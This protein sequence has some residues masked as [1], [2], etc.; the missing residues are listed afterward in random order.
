MARDAEALAPYLESRAHWTFGY[1]T[2]EREHDCVRFCDAGV[3]AVSGRHPLKSF[4]GTWTTERGA[5]RVLARHGGMAQAVSTVMAEIPVT[6]AQR[7]DVGLTTENVLVLVE[8]ATVVGLTDTGYLRLPR[9]ALTQA[10][11]VIDG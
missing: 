10:W 7:G 8:G 6:F 4:S 11:T 3:A 1:G 2:G 5:A 9:E